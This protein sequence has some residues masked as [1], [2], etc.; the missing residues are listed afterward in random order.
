MKLPRMNV[1]LNPPP[2]PEKDRNSN[3]PEI[4]LPVVQRSLHPLHF[5][6]GYPQHPE[7]AELG[8]E[9]NHEVCI[10]PNHQIEKLPA[11]PLT[12]TFPAVLSQRGT[13]RETRAASSLLNEEDL[14]YAP[15]DINI[16]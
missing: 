9:K 11:A 10:F 7:T 1:S 5:L 14:Q 12:G 6:L 13:F 16:P 2:P 3:R 15:L 8:K 4:L